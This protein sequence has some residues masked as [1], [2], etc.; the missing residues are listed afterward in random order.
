VTDLRAI[1]AVA[2]LALA[3][4]LPSLGNGFAF[5]DEGDI[6]ENPT[7]VDASG[8]I[9]VLLS[10]YRGQ[11]PPQRSPYRPVT[12]LTLWMNWVAGGDGPAGFHV[13]N[14][15]LH[16]LASAL[17]VR[18]LIA[19]GCSASGALIGGALFAVHP[20]HVEAVANVVGRADVLATIFCLVAALVWV[21]PKLGSVS[22]VVLVAIAYALA[23]GSKEIAVFLPG[24]LLALSWARPAGRRLAGEVARLTPTVAVLGGYLLVRLSAL[25]LL[26]QQDT[27][28]YIAELTTAE[29]LP[30]AVASLAVMG[31]LLFAPWNLAADYGPNVIQVVGFASAGFWMGAL[32][33]GLCIALAWQLRRRERL[34]TL[35]LAWIGL[36]V[37]VV[38]NLPFAIGIWVAERT[39]YLAS[40]GVG[41]GAAALVGALGAHAPSAL[42][43][44]L[45][46]ATL[47]VAVGAWRTVDRIPSW[48][49]TEVAFRTLAEEH[50]ES[51][52]GQWWLARRLTDAGDYEAG[53]RWFERATATS[54][55]DLRLKLDYARALLL[56]G[57]PAEAEA[58]VAP[59]P[60]TDPARFVYLAQSRIMTDR[61]DEAREDLREG[62]ARFPND[63]RLID[64]AREL[65]IEP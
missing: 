53:L 34:G 35:A 30:T 15:L 43:G 10:P 7:V 19:L 47:A 6:L 58:L 3:V 44:T 23:L 18:L 48:H 40:V 5:D 36:S 61:P 33:A 55:N 45:A 8:P 57:R 29:R 31:R 51:F 64:Q 49:D 42:R 21:S 46:A 13:V 2:L 17:V 54:P 9:D 50:P 38:S 63:A 14:V 39:L 41:I 52:R 22:R 59:L 26:V 16:V 12:S 28:P 24:L 32:S 65:G 37:L 11:V 4:Y 56:A 1:L 25:G 20:I 62:L 27:A 60:G